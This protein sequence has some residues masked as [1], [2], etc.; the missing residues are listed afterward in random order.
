MVFLPGAME[1]NM[2]VNGKVDTEK[3]KVSILLK[4]ELFMKEIFLKIDWKEM[5]L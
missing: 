2:R 3:G 5:E 1:K 4:V